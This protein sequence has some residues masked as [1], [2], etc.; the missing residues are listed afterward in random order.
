MYNLTKNYRIILWSLKNIVSTINYVD[1]ITSQNSKFYR[2]LIDSFCKT[3]RQ[4]FNPKLKFY[5]FC[6]FI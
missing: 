6:D 2:F 5:D 3:K 4:A 1:R